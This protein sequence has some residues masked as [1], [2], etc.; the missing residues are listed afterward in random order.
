MDR[1]QRSGKTRERKINVFIIHTFFKSDC[2]QYNI[3]MYIIRL[4]I[5]LYLET[6]NAVH[7]IIIRDYGE[8]NN[9]KVVSKSAHLLHFHDTHTTNSFGRLLA[10]YRLAK[11]ADLNKLFSSMVYK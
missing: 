3:T 7:K 4:Y 11:T 5:T 8:S 9:E 2:Q 6:Q 1:R 10:F